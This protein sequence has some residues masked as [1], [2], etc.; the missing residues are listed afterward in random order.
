[1]L[2]PEAESVATRVMAQL[3]LA[4][5]DLHSIVVS[6]RFRRMCQSETELSL[7]AQS[8]LS[9]KWLKSQFISD[10]RVR[11]TV[12]DPNYFGIAL[13]FTTG[14]RAHL[15]RLQEL[16]EAKGIKLTDEG[17]W[18]GNDEIICP[19][20]SDIY[21]ALDLPF[22]E[23][24][25]RENGDE[26]EWAMRGTLSHIVNTAAIKGILHNH[27]VYSDGK[28]TLGQMAD[29]AQTRGYEYFGVADH[30]R[31]SANTRG[32]NVD[33]A[34]HQ[35]DAIEAL[36][37]HSH[38]S[39]N[40]HNS[41]NNSHRFRIL[42]GLE[43]DIEKNGAIDVPLALLD[44]LDYLVCSIHNHN[45]LSTEEQTA[46]LVRAIRNPYTSVLGHVK[47]LRKATKGSQPTLQTFDLEKA[48]DT[49]DA[50]QDP[51]L[52]DGDKIMVG[53]NNGFVLLGR[54]KNPG[55]YYPPGVG[56]APLTLSRLIALGGGFETYAKKSSVVIIHQGRPGKTVV[57][58]KSIVEDGKLD[59]DV[60]LIPGD[61]VFVG[62]SKL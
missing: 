21:R 6:G 32:M 17:M 42:T 3:T 8:N 20:E 2:L 38:H 30:F 57:D 10:L 15:R 34:L 11:L 12:C 41:H 46:R 56:G 50:Q 35:I 47:L 26:I 43:A 31:G 22:I 14:S 45:D 49:G 52:Q 24:E 7:V 23:P 53:A 33:V 4:F 27:T 18:R 13:L 36:N 54:V 25:F 1:M 62:E 9:Q 44:R 28:H 19:E 61:M 16:A 51:I 5:P 58:V 59:L 29:A 39:H 40:S 60:P 55:I 48:L 37:T